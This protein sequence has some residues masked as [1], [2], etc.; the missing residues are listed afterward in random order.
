M[1]LTV[2]LTVL[3]TVF[4][5][6]LYNNKLKTEH[7]NLKVENDALKSIP[8]STEETLRKAVKAQLDVLHLDTKME[9]KHK[10][11][12]ISALNTLYATM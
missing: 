8:V 9:S 5:N 4:V 12:Y 11:A 7:K 6:S 2:I 1:I 10:Q 3:V